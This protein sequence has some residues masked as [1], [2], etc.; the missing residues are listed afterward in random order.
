MAGRRAVLLYDVKPARDAAIAVR[1]QSG[2]PWRLSGV[3]AGDADSETL[4]RTIA[5]KG[6]EAVAGRLLLAAD[7]APISVTWEPPERG[8]RDAPRKKSS[9]RKSIAK[10]KVAKKSQVAKKSAK[11][12]IKKTAKKKAAKKA[13]KRT[14]ASRTTTRTRSRGKRHAR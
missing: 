12:V 14:S 8:P 3:M 11:K 2:G 10:S 9:G 1:V 6:V 7:G 5:T 13:T 4:A